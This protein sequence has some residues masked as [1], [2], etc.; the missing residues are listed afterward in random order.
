MRR[1]RRLAAALLLASGVASAQTTVLLPP[2]AA[3]GGRS[4]SSWV[5][6]WW[7]WAWSFDLEISP[8]TDESGFHCGSRQSGDVW[9]L[10]GSFESERVIRSCVVPRGKHLFFPLLT[11]VVF[12][13]S[14]QE[15]TCAQAI[16]HAASQTAD[17]AGLVLA[18]DGRRYDGLV[19]HRQAT[20][21]C[22]DLGA[23]ARPPEKLS[24]AAA[25]GYFVMLK[26]LAP[27]RHVVE[28]GGVL[29]EMIQAVTYTITVE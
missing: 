18:V 27:G 9:F 8:L 25:N 21:G 20:I 24:P 28:F 3:I 4:Q 26:P 29:P 7:Q 23:Q 6:R 22:F 11:T 1:L 13:Q 10:A 19:A 17:P 2:D 15:L 12:P 16:A 5:Q 14:M